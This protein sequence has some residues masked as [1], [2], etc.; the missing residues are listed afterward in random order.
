LRTALDNFIASTCFSNW[1]EEIKQMDGEAGASFDSKLEVPVLIRA[2]QSQREPPSSL[3]GNAL[4]AR[5]KKCGL[6]ESNFDA[7]LHKVM[8][9][10]AYWTKI[11]TLGFVTIPHNVSRLL[12]RKDALRV[13]RENVML[14]VRDYNSIIHTVS[15]E[16]RSLFKEHLDM[17]DRTIDPGIRRHSWGSTADNFVYACRKECQDV[18]LNVKKFQSNVTKV[19]GE[20]E[21]ISGTTLTNV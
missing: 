12:Q 8:V 6:L 1:K 14:I 11:Q 9:E 4:F 5:D 10:V 16:E 20:F 15:D 3:S 17:L 2:D 21:K 19:N 18:F 7:D 13:L